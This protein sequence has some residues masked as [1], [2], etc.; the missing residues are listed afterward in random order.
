[1]PFGLR[2]L[3]LATQLIRLLARKPP[4]PAGRDAG[5]NRVARVALEA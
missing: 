2:G 1:V 5:Q 3:E 4:R